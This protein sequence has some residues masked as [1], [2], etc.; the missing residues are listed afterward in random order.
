VSTST[1]SR[2]RRSVSTQTL[3]LLA[4]YA[5]MV[6]VFTAINRTFFSTAVAGNIL[7]DWGPIVL[8]AVGETYVIVSGGIDLSVGGTLGIAGVTSALVMQHLTESG[9]ASAVTIALG[10]CIAAGTGVLVGLLNGLLI[11]R[12][13]LVPF[14]AT[15]A[16]MGGTEGLSLVITGGTPVAG[17]PIAGITFGSTTYL[18]VFTVPVMIVM[19]IVLVA[20]LYL[21]KARLGRWTFA[22]GSSQFASRGA[23][24]NVERQVYK[25]YVLS[26]LLSGLAGM[27]VYLRLGSGSASS[28]VGQELQAIAAVVIG[29]ASLYGGVGRMAGTVIGALIVTTVL[30]GLIIVGVQANWQQVVIAVI[31]VLAVASQGLGGL[32]R[33]AR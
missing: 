21:H 19:V 1:T 6:V 7:Q 10:T 9:Q 30:S 32:Q 23:G 22:I 26:G 28:G 4:V 25:I 12:L 24:I 29:G 17:G 14:I 3:L 15:L 11:N 8:M 2:L 33:K 18:G 31:I 5:L 20:G 16:T 27:F 13:H